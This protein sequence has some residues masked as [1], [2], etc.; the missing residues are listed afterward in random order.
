MANP[1][2]SESGNKRWFS[3]NKMHRTDGPACEYASGS[4]AWY[5]HGR[6]HRT[7][8]P[9]VEHPDGY[10]GWWL[11]GEKYTFDEWLDA[12]TYLTHGEKVIMKL[13]YG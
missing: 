12:N 2:I 5:I 1:E 13:Q 9:A 7:D 8:G 10:R 4:K 3:N 6:L 11:N